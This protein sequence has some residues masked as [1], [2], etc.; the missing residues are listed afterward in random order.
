MDQI[1]EE[2]PFCARTPS[3]EEVPL[4]IVSGRFLSQEMVASGELF[5]ISKFRVNIYH[6]PPQRRSLYGLEAKQ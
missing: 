2:K 5:Q 1:V 3:L 6:L 4:K